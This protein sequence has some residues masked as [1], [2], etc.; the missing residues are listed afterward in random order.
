MT[1]S[2]LENS[3][4]AERGGEGEGEGGLD[5]DEREEH[6]AGESIDAPALPRELP[7]YLF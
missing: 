5:V 4:N 6:P 2:T 3:A 7:F 1:V